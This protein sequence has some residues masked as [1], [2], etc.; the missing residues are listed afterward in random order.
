MDKKFRILLAVAALVVA[1]I[2]PSCLSDGDDTI[3]V[4]GTLESSN[5]NNNNQNNKP[6]VPDQ[7]EGI[8]RTV[9]K[10]TVDQLKQ[11]MSIYED[12][13]PPNLEGLFLIKPF[14]MVYCE[15][16]GYK[17]GDIVAPMLLNLKNQ[18][19]NK[20]TIDI[21]T[22]EGFSAGS[23]YG[24]YISGSGN[25]FTIYFNTITDNQSTKGAGII[26][27]TEAVIISGT[28]TSTGISNLTYAMTMV[29]K[30]NDPYKEL[31]EVGYYRIASD[32]DH[33]SEYTNPILISEV[34]NPRKTY[35]VDDLYQICIYTIYPSD[36]TVIVDNN[37]IDAQSNTDL[38]VSTLPTSEAGV[39]TVVLKGVC[40]GVN[41]EDV[42]FSYT[43]EPRPVKPVLS[44]TLSSSPYYLGSDIMLEVTS[45][46]ASNLSVLVNGIEIGSKVSADS[47]SLKLPSATGGTFTVTLKGSTSNFDADDVIFTYT[48]DYPDYIDLDLPSG[49]LWATSNIGASAPWYYGNL[50]AWGET[51]AKTSFAW[52]NYLY[53]LSDENSLIK[54]CND[55]NLSYNNVYTDSYTVL[56]SGDDAATVNLGAGWSTPTFEDWQELIDYCDLEY[57]VLY[58]NDINISYTVGSVEGIVCYSKANHDKHIFIPLTNNQSNMCMSCLWS[59]TLNA[60]NCKEAYDMIFYCESNHS[61]AK[62]ILDKGY[63]QERK[64]GLYVRPVRH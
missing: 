2:F 3:I 21:F 63:A 52:D 50:F 12:N 60:D 41:M 40:N 6:F 36:M 54:Y 53:T 27:T 11:H 59:S 24:A 32:N 61:S 13:N 57:T 34:V 17:P 9:P 22:R 8:Y 51:T 20:G 19:N 45:Q 55:P 25:N 16:N 5:G 56:E 42:T 58:R 14:E 23:S 39:H 48:V 64:N 62:Y 33:M 49:T 26:H 28:L 18:D 10:E 44:Y 35:Y 15:D 7:D 38:Y 29:D 37:V 43:V 1:P 4:S 46:P 47:Y 31:M 30:D